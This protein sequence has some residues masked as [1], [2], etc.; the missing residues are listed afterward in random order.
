M[1]LT[2]DFVIREN[3]WQIASLVTQKSLFTVT[4]AVFFIY[5]HAVYRCNTTNI[6]MKY[7]VFI[8][9]GMQYIEKSYMTKGAR[10]HGLCAPISVIKVISKGARKKSTVQ[11]VPIS[12]TCNKQSIQYNNTEWNFQILHIYIHLNTYT[13]MHILTSMYIGYLKLHKVTW[14]H[15]Q[16]RRVI[17]ANV[18]NEPIAQLGLMFLIMKFRLWGPQELEVFCSLVPRKVT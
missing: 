5:C 8:L 12:N 3:H 10:S 15:L 7:V 1:I 14:H 18:F 17:G 16:Q 9:F 13:Y 6:R 4:H 11:F 2:H